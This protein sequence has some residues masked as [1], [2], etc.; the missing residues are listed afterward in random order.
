MQQTIG[1]RLKV[2]VSG[3]YVVYQ[4]GTQKDPNFSCFSKFDPPKGSKIQILPRN[5]PTQ[6]G[7]RFFDVESACVAAL[8]LPDPK[9]DR[10]TQK[11]DTISLSQIGAG[12]GTAVKLPRHLT[13]WA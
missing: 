8:E 12:G 10:V 5:D 11:R 1:R 6:C 3:R 4:Q 13:K 2:L 9:R 7:T